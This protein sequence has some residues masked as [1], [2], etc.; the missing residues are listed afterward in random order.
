MYTQELR[1]PREARSP[2]ASITSV[3]PGDR[4]RPNRPNWQEP[5]ILT[6]VGLPGRKLCV[7]KVAL[8]E[9]VPLWQ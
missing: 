5:C 9:E 1:G 6:E 8:Q 2:G 4:Q 7:R 3:E